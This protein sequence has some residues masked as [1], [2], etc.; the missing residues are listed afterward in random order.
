M[1]DLQAIADRFEIETLRAEFTD[2]ANPLGC[3]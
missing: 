2:A 3:S 1:S